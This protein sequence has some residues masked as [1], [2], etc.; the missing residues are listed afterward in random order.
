MNQDQT[1]ELLLKTRQC[2]TDF[3][4]IFSG[5]KSSKVNGL[6]KPDSR[7]I[8]LHNHN[9]E[10]DN[11]LIYTALHE[12][13]HHLHSESRGGSLSPRAHGPDFWAIF[14]SLLEDAEK[15]K[16][17]RNIFEEVSELEDLADRIRTECLSENGKVMKSLGAL[18]IQAEELCRKHGARFEDFIDRALGMSRVT[19]K[20]CMKVSAWDINPQLGYDGMKLVAGV[21]DPAKR[22]EAEKALLSG[23][24]PDSV[25]VALKKDK[26]DD[27]DPAEFLQKER[28]RLERTIESLKARLKDVESKIRELDKA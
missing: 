17:Y 23:H 28:Q 9:F 8:L 20:T 6:Y 15:K 7:E 1:R 18:M 24:S 26:D 4:V 3:T 11:E 13:A 14:H 27:E 5:K 21:G 2:K 12:Y 19:A 16:L 25:R 22:R 10:N